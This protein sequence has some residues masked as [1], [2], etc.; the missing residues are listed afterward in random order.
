M[1]KPLIGAVVLAAA[2]P[3]VLTG[4]SSND[5]SV[6]GDGNGD[7][8][9]TSSLQDPE[10]LLRDLQD[11]GSVPKDFPKTKD[12]RVEMS[13]DEFALAWK[14]G[15]MATGC[16]PG[17]AMPNS[18]AS[19]LLIADGALNDI[20]QCGDIWQATQADGSYVAWN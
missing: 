1:K 18:T 9:D 7:T 4:C 13:G 15:P 14:G 6:E 5:T 8:N 11:A 17:D 19:I 12:L 2:L 20:Q 3:L 10:T 16:K